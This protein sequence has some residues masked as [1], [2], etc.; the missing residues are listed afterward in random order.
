MRLAARAKAVAEDERFDQLIIFCIMLVGIATFVQMEFNRVGEASA[1]V[2]L[3]LD[4]VGYVTLAVFTIEV[5]AKII[6]CGCRAGSTT[7]PRARSSSFDFAVV[8]VP[9]A[10]PQPAAG[11]PHRRGLAGC[12]SSRS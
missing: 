11:R 9:Y 1:E 5:V 8:A 10:M 4:V 3:F 2:R 12:G 6:A 7:R